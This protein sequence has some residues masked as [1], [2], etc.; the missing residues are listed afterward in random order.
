MLLFS[1][2]NSRNLVQIDSK[3]EPN[4]NDWQINVQ[5]KSESKSYSNDWHP[6]ENYNQH[7]SEKSQFP[8]Q[9]RW[10]HTPEQIRDISN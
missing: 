9:L 1:S 2:S 8:N 3:S 6:F 5:I 7:L 10:D 4:G